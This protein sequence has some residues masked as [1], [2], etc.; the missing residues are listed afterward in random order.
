MGTGV[1]NMVNPLKEEG[2]LFGKAGP[3]LRPRTK[4]IW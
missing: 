3:R 2:F 1:S 4:R